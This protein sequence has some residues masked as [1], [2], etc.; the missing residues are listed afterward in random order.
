MKTIVKL[1]IL[2]A[3]PVFVFIYW[4]NSMKQISDLHGKHELIEA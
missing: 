3:T 1:T 4:R 2:F